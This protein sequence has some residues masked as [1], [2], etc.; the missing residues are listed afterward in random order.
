MKI[1]GFIVKIYTFIA[2]FR[3]LI[4]IMQGKGAYIFIF[5]FTAFNSLLAQKAIR[6]TVLDKESKN[7]LIAAT[8]TLYK[9]TSIIFQTS[10]DLQ[11]SFRISNIPIGQYSL[12]AT[13]LG[14]DPL[15]QFNVYVNSAKETILNLE[16]EQSISSINTIEVRN[17]KKGELDW[18]SGS[19]KEFSVDET[20]RFAGSRSDPA[21]MVSNYAGVQG[22][23]D[24]RNDIVI[25]G[26]SPLG[27]LWRYEG[28]DIPNP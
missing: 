4:N 21:R 12:K 17:S 6:G 3:I 19:A 7:F 10:T 8:I 15:V 18:P 13:Y 11:G 2:C 27:M 23:D 20:N 16:L 22:S 9:D 1:S 26:N 14:Y 5:F 25:R 28:I 24:S